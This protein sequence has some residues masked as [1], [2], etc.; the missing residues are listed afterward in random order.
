MK[1]EKCE[2]IKHSPYIQ[3]LARL[4]FNIYTI[5]SIKNKKAGHFFRMGYA[6]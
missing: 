5:G 6:A 3:G 1:K 2:H 4:F